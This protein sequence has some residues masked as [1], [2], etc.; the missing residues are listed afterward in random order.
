MATP[1]GRQRALLVVTGPTQLIELRRVAS[2]LRGTSLEPTFV[3]TGPP[4]EEQ[5]ALHPLVAA[6]YRC[7]DSHG[8]TI[9]PGRRSEPEAGADAPTAHP[10]QEQPSRASSASRRRLRLP[11]AIS[12]LKNLLGWTRLYFFV[13]RSAAQV[14]AAERAAVVV[15]AEDNVSS[16]TPCWTKAAEARG[17][18]VVIVP[19]TTAGPSEA[20]EAF[21]QEPSHRCDRS[22]PNRAWARISPKW[23]FDHPSG[24]LVRLPAAQALALNLLRL[25][26]P[27]PWILHSGRATAVAVESRAMLDHYTA[28]GLP[29]EKLVLTGALTDDLLAEG[30]Q[31]RALRRERWLKA[32]GLDPLLPVVLCALPPDQSGTR[33]GGCSAEFATYEELAREFVS[34]LTGVPGWNVV[35]RP[36]PRIA[37]NDPRLPPEAGFRYVWD[38]T[39]RLVTQADLFVASVSATIRWAIACG[40]PVVNYDVYRY[41]YGDY[42]RAP[43]VVHVDEAGEFARA[44]ARLAANRRALE[45]LASRQASVSGEWGCLDGQSAERVVRLITKIATSGRS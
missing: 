4:A 29:R 41:N 30:M 14:L 28:L 21:A 45:E 37:A 2:A 12:T 3:W 33:E 17:I 32:C 34:V 5:T 20:A 10:G 9:E 42:E 16:W 25:S 23:S 8:Q 15:M 13:V 7:M 38:D 39:A 27:E 19:F 1:N 40:I 31:Q 24:R 35:V 11:G 18:G 43:G 22:L 36:H 26:P 44:Y 6:G